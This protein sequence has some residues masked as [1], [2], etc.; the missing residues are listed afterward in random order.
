[1][2]QVKSKTIYGTK[3]YYNCGNMLIKISEH[4]QKNI[5]PY[6]WGSKVMQPMMLNDE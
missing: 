4:D 1:M 6:E 5:F 3:E 2:Q